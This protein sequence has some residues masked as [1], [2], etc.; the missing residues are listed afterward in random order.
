MKES[1]FL[2]ELC[3][4]YAGIF[5]AALMVIDR[6]KLALALA[7]VMSMLGMVVFK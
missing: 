2:L 6:A 1:S 3:S 7:L 5:L 4:I